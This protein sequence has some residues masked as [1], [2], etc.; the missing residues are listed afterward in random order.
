MIGSQGQ[1]E[2]SLVEKHCLISLLCHKNK[3]GTIKNQ[4]LNKCI[5]HLFFLPQIP[6]EQNPT[7][8]PNWNLGKYLAL[9]LL[10][11]NNFL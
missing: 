10:P 9:K 11:R 5:N 4:N 1:K 6:I 7:I 8:S 3:V 2:V